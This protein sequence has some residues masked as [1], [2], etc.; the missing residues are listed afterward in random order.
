VTTVLL[1]CSIAYNL[2]GCFYSGCCTA[3]LHLTRM[4]V[5]SVVVVLQYLHSTLIY[6]ATLAVVLQY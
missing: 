3:V 1:Y 6:V 2:V 5:V 4:D